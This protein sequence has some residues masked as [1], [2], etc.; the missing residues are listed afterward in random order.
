MI[1]EVEYAFVKAA[2]HA[3]GDPK[4]LEFFE[5]TSMPDQQLIETKLTD[6]GLPFDKETIS[7]SV[8][9]RYKDADSMRQAG[10]RVTKA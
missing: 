9:Q 3:R 7:I 8:S 4:Q 10:I 2:V 1:I 5:A 6:L